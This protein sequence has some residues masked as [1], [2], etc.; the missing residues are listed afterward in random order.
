MNLKA[1]KRE[2]LGKKVKQMRKEGAVPASIYGPKREAVSLSVSPREFKK[3]FDSVGYSTLFDMEIDGEKEAS[4]VLVKEVQANVLTDEILHVSFYEVDMNSTLHASIPVVLT[5][6]SPAVK[7]NI[8]LLV[9]TVSTIDVVCLPKDLPH[10]FDIDVEGLAQVGDSIAIRDVALPHGVELA[11]G[12]T[13]ETSV[14]YISAPQKVV[15]TVATE[16]GEEGGDAEAGESAEST[17]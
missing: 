5:G 14:V 11:P 12:V 17:E 15:A 6:T 3:L 10:Q 9:N 16:E 13:V 1:T 7:N 2:L 4:K 8:G